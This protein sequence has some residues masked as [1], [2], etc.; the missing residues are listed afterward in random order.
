MRID[1]KGAG[2]AEALALTTGELVRELCYRFGSETNVLEQLSDP[3]LQ[4]RSF[5]E[6]E[7]GQ[8]LA[9]DIASREARIERGIGILKYHLHL[10]TLQSQRLTFQMRDVETIELNGASRRCLQA[11]NAFS[12]GGLAATGFT[13]E[14]E[15]F[16]ASNIERDAVN[17]MDMSDNVGKDAAANRK[18]LLEILDL[19]YDVRAGRR[20]IR[21]HGITHGVTADVRVA[22]QQ[23]A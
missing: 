3:I 17:S 6:A 2:D 14:A 22:S 19:E 15:R 13:D 1:G 11:I 8:R 7:V 5:G 23:A 9:D 12:D 20:Y 10:A 18:V 21:V 4:C 16:A